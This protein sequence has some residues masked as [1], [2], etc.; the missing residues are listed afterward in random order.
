MACK[1]LKKWVE[2]EKEHTNSNASAKRIVKEHIAEWG[3]SY[4]PELIKMERRLKK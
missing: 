1:I 3:C 2:I 4:Y